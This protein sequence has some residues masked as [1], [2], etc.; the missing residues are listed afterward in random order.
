M[1]VYFGR[2]FIVAR[3]A[4]HQATISCHSMLVRLVPNP[5]TLPEADLRRL[6][7]SVEFVD[8]H[9]FK[10]HT[11][12]DADP[13]QPEVAQETEKGGFDECFFGFVNKSTT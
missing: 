1:C 9:L 6:E 2:D 5:D 3:T 8:H 7:H 12:T 13:T 10:N 11:D 4:M